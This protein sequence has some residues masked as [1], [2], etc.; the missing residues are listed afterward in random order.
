M[1][2]NFCSRGKQ[3]VFQGSP[4]ARPQSDFDGGQLPVLSGWDIR[5]QLLFGERAGQERQKKWLERKEAEGSKTKQQAHSEFGSFYQITAAR[6]KHHW[7]TY[8]F[9]YVMGQSI[10]SNLTSGLLAHSKNVLHNET[11]FL[12]KKEVNNLYFQYKWSPL[13]HKMLSL[14]RNYRKEEMSKQNIKEKQFKYIT[15][16]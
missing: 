13:V 3:M 10:T 12:Y 7:Y 5:I 16:S 11:N 9:S 14:F 4:L 1:T 2:L 15:K 6:N 8:C